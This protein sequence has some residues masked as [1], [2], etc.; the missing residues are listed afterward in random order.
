MRIVR[1]WPKDVPA[2]H[3]FVN[4]N[5]ERVYIDTVDYRPL[6]ELGESFIHLDWDIAVERNA[7]RDFAQKCIAD[8]DTV[9]V[10]PYKGYP[11]RR[12][13]DKWAWA[14]HEKWYVWRNSNPG[15]YGSKI[16][17]VPGDPFCHW[18]APGF[19][20]VPFEYWK[21]Y[22]DSTTEAVCEGFPDW[23]HKN[24]GWDEFPV[25]WDVNA[26]H[27]NYSMRDVMLGIEE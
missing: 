14:N 21:G 11:T 6:V 7:L 2:D 12:R 1:S 13:H 25:E 15:G 16:E 24:I 18:F 27:L 22:C 20:Y 4:D 10:G 5:C 19:M 8:P 3:P 9:R 17:L 23:Y 26:I